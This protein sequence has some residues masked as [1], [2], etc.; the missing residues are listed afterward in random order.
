M[1]ADAEIIGFG[2]FKK[3][4]IGMDFLPYSDDEYL[5][6][7]EGKIIVVQFCHCNTTYQSNL[8][9]TACGTDLYDF[10]THYLGRGKGIKFDELKELLEDGGIAEWTE[11]DLFN[12]DYL[13]DLGTFRFFFIPNR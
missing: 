9:A 1:G 4:F 8:L 5:D 10:N 13:V 3:D 7:E 11:K 12:L 6:V 2:P